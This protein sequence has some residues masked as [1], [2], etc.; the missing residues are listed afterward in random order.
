[1]SGTEATQASRDDVRKSAEYLLGFS[2]GQSKKWKYIRDMWG[3]LGFFLFLVL[4]LAVPSLY[5]TYAD[6]QTKQAKISA[7]SHAAD[8]TACIQAVGK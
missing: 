7:C 1:M 2:E 3:G 4:F 5:G 6:H 8:V